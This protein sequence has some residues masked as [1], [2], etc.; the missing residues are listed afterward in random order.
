MELN[1]GYHALT[2]LQRARL[3]GQYHLYNAF[4]DLRTWAAWHNGLDASERS[5][6]RFYRQVN[7]PGALDW[8]DVRRV[9]PNE[10][11]GVKLGIDPEIGERLS[12]A[13]SIA[14]ASMGAN[15][16]VYAKYGQ[17]IAQAA[18]INAYPFAELNAPGMGRIVGVTKEAKPIDSARMRKAIARDIFMMRL[19]R[20]SVLGIRLPRIVCDIANHYVP[21]SFISFWERFP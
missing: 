10:T 19:R 13:F 16:G 2:R 14:S 6:V 18:K 12:R 20:F 17:S 21:M 1:N 9:P 7:Q 4:G 15:A 5:F 3:A 11:L 8:A